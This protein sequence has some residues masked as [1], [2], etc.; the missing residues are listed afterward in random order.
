MSAEWV[1]IKKAALIAKCDQ[2]RI[3]SRCLSGEIECYKVHYGN[4]EKHERFVFVLPLKA[5]MAWF[6]ANPTR[7]KQQ[8]AAIK[9]F[10]MNCHSIKCDG[11]TPSSAGKVKFENKFIRDCPDCRSVLKQVF[12]KRKQP[13]AGL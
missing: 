1:T 8:T 3:R 6:A 11:Y 5:F 12:K 2:E 10:T 4:Q 7:V 9:D 13:E